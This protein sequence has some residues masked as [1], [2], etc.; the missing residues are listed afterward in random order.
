MSKETLVLDYQ[1]LKSHAGILL[2]GDY[3]SLTQLH[4]V[5]HD[6]NDCHGSA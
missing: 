1:L 3:H 6:V 2:I 4:E 5:V